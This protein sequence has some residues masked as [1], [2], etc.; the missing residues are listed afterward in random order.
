MLLEV[1]RAQRSIGGDAAIMHGSI[2]NRPSHWILASLVALGVFLWGSGRATRWFQAPP[3]VSAAR[4]PAGPVVVRRQ[5][6]PPKP[7]LGQV[8]GEVVDRLGWPVVAAEV[9]LLGTDQAAA[10]A[11]TDAAGRFTLTAA[12]AS[13]R[14][15]RVSARGRHREREVAVGLD[16]ML[17]VLQDAVPWGGDDPTQH[18]QPGIGLLMGEGYL[19][20]DRGRAVPHGRVIV[21]ETGAGTHA[22]VSG[23]FSVPLGID[24]NTLV[25]Y[26]DD[27]RIGVSEPARPT[28]TQGKVPLA[29]LVLEPGL[30]L[31]GFL[32]D[33]EGQP[34][35][36]ATLLLENAGIPRRAITGTNGFFDLRGLVSGPSRLM[37]EP[38][39]GNLGFRRDLIVDGNVDVGDLA[40][41]R[42]APVRIRVLDTAGA[43]VALVHVLATEAEIRQAYGQA[44]RMGRVVLAG[45]GTGALA[46][47][48]RSPEEFAELHVVGFD[49]ARV[50]L[51][52]ESATIEGK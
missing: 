24:E 25:A 36:G 49:S 30:R 5:T 39:R 17:I 26:D 28:R 40:L 41:E 47:E 33:A 50:E 15:L 32:K 13:M 44:D 34:C 1:S 35:S 9:M 18:R 20:D 14:R 10:R 11:H 22:D 51:V 42:P 23:H 45:L 6:L 7:T 8:R 2:M 29:D 12:G 46:F 38:I 48:V 27:G 16:D 43:P 4:A 37:A 19:K 31:S 21:R 52:V 3:S